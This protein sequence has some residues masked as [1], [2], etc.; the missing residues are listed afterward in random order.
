M[1]WP[2]VLKDF[3]SVVVVHLKFHDIT[4]H[5]KISQSFLR[6]VFTFGKDLG[7]R[8]HNHDFKLQLLH[9][10]LNVPHCKKLEVD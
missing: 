1:F 7:T 10:V 2:P 9:S 6:S 4:T 3:E 8:L 5:D